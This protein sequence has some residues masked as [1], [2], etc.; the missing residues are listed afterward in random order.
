[1]TLEQDRADIER[2]AVSWQDVPEH[3]QEAMAAKLSTMLEYLDPGE[4]AERQLRHDASRLLRT[5]EASL[6]RAR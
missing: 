2:V 3:E 4:D 6:G 1:M 5:I